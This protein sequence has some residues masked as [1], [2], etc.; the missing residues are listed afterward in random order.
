M[1]ILVTGGAG[2][3]GINMIRKLIQKDI[4]NI[5]SLDIEPFLYPEKDIVKAVSGDIR[6]PDAV[7]RSYEGVD[8]VIHCAAALPLYKKSDIYSTDVDGTRVML[9]QAE[10][11]A[12][13]R[14]IHISTTAVYG[15][16]DHHPIFEDDR[17]SGVGDYGKAK[18]LAEKVCLQFR[19]KG[20]CT[21]IL[22]PKS[23][24]GPERLGVFTLLYDWALDGRNFPLL[25][26]GKNRYQLLD[27][28]DFCEAIY[29]CMVRP[30]DEVNDTFNIGAK[31]FGTMKEDYQAVLDDAGFGKKIVTLPDKPAV[32]ALKV[33]E[34]FK[35][36]PLYMWVYETASKDSFV[37][38]E[39]AESK[40][41]YK[42]LFSN[43]DA[44]LR[45]FRWYMKNTSSFV[46]TGVSHRVP[47][48]QGILKLAKLAF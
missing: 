18:I 3:L 4:R 8:I 26:D 9:Q 48:S 16:P 28:E 15:V 29:L 5:V 32:A 37:S 22:R 1:R 41:G 21:P 40:I 23:F 43:K 6:D 35:I 42:P 38:I 7:S 14:F 25:G 30:R 33:L 39:K 31:E 47:W 17:L 13:E 45:N 10:K 20:M 11:S 27:V 46:K 12:I 24:I 36:S 44:L 2:F 19:D 34:F